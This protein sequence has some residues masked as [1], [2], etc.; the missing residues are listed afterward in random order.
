MG[1]G[2]FGIIELLLKVLIG[3]AFSGFKISMHNIVLYQLSL[4]FPI[5]YQIS[6]HCIIGFDFYVFTAYFA[7]TLTEDRGTDRAELKPTSFFAI[8][9]CSLFLLFVDL[10]HVQNTK[11]IEAQMNNSP[12]ET[13][14]FARKAKQ[15]A[16]SRFVQHKTK[17]LCSLPL[18]FLELPNQLVLSASVIGRLK[19]IQQHFT[20]STYPHVFQ[21]LLRQFMSWISRNYSRVIF[22]HVKTRVMVMTPE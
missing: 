2:E 5:F 13:F 21:M 12:V 1:E 14:G 7:C 20:V 6:S 11:C 17:P 15:C 16:R 10:D 4:T 3:F 8:F 22:L 18:E 19:Y 9:V